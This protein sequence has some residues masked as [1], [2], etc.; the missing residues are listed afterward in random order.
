MGNEMNCVSSKSNK[1]I[2]S[3]EQEKNSLLKNDIL[4]SLKML[5]QERTS[6]QIIATSK[7]VKKLKR[8]YNSWIDRP[9]KFFLHFNKV[10]ELSSPIMDSLS[11]I[12]LQSQFNYNN[13]SIYDVV[14]EY[15]IDN[16]YNSV[17]NNDIFHNNFNLV[18]DVIFKELFQ[19]LSNQVNYSFFNQEIS[20]SIN[21]SSNLSKSQLIKEF[22]EEE[23][24]NLM[25]DNY[26]NFNNQLNNNNDNDELVQANFKMSDS[27]VYKV[28]NKNINNKTALK[29]TKT[30]YTKFSLNRGL[31]KTNKNLKNYKDFKE[32][33][34]ENN[35]FNIK[36]GQNASLSKKDLLK[37]D[38]NVRNSELNK[39]GKEISTKK[40][41]DLRVSS[42]KNT[43]KTYIKSHTNINNGSIENPLLSKRSDKKS[44]KSLLFR[45]F[46]NGDKDIDD[47]LIENLDFIS[48]EEDEVA[49]ENNNINKTFKKKE[50]KIKGAFQ[51]NFNDDNSKKFKTLKKGNTIVT[52]SFK[53]KLIE[54]KETEDEVVN[55]KKPFYVN[56]E[57]FSRLTRPEIIKRRGTLE[58][59]ETKT[60]IIPYK[61][62]IDVRN[63]NELEENLNKQKE[64]IKIMN[65]Q[66][67]NKKLNNKSSRNS[68]EANA[69]NDLK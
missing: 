58:Y 62:V 50:T 40:D 32:K 37:R 52:K 61:I 29:N 65:E 45:N 49:F 66:L 67:L 68:F 2:F 56:S 34:K 27:K 42:K 63:I 13:T 57:A 16:N 30:P 31:N 4:N 1:N 54:N 53:S 5:R 18:R 17:Y 38:K 9:T 33:E 10:E 20:D 36:K 55:M 8:E 48:S 59:E 23:Q 41:R 25:A 39:K 35:K 69:K 47:F 6:D 15:K 28:E 44:N 3:E 14:C 51:N 11:D 64:E 21:D 19:N 46:E 12:I 43:Q 24:E 7:K 22:S 60:N 26:I